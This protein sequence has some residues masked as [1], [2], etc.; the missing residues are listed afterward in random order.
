VNGRKIAS[1][2]V[3][4]ER[5]VTYHGVSLN[6][7]ADLE[8]FDCIIPCGESGLNVTSLER[9]SSTLLD[10]H[11]IKELFIGEFAG[12][13]HYTDV[14]EGSWVSSRHPD[15]LVRPAPQSDPIDRMERMLSKMG[16][17]T[18]CQSAHCPNLGECFGRGTA[19][20]MILG[21]RCTR[22]CRFCAVDSGVPDPVDPEEPLRVA[23]AARELGLEHVVITSVTRDDLG[24]GGAGQFARTIEA[25]RRLSPT[26]T[27]EVLVPDFKGSVKALDTVVHARPDIFNHNLET[28]P[29][30][31][32]VVRRQARYRRSLRVLEYAARAGLRVKSGLILGL[33][34]TPD[35]V[36]TVLKELRRTDCQMLTLGQY[37]SPSEDH[38]PVARYVPPWEFDELAR[39]A[40]TLGFAEVAAGPLV[41]S[42]YRADEM[43]SAS[44][45]KKKQ[46]S[47]G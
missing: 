6:V 8:G 30:L 44:G 5:W 1:V 26:A 38:L 39:A 40:R 36:L 14:V 16:L 47:H 41:R 35:E 22:D 11:R 18:V 7:S 34:E 21:S 42:S 27:A 32:P 4:V 31:Y 15:W 24:D 46:A 43:L 33:G 19:T 29:G 13:F 10:L 12:A 17:A 3:A 2:G 25:V 45:G 20:F 9:E 23:R 37:L 28:V